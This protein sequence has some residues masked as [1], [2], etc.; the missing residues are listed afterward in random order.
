MGLAGPAGE[1]GVR[2]PP[3]NL[4]F[5]VFLVVRLGRARTCIRTHVIL[6]SVVFCVSSIGWE[7]SS[8][9]QSCSIG[10]V[11]TDGCGHAC[12]WTHFEHGMHGA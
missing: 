5:N 1:R 4:H 7:F 8:P 2:G 11:V 3:G 9:E 10:S 6:R 12:V